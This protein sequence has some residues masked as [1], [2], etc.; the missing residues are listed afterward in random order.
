MEPLPEGPHPD[1]LAQSV[2]AAGQK[3]AE[4]AAVAALLAQVLAQVRARHAL[5]AA[6]LA[7]L[8]EADRAAIAAQWATALHPEWLAD[9]TLPETARAWGAALAHEGTDPAAGAA[10]DAAEARLRELHPYAMA[11]YDRL[12]SQGLAREE[13]MRQAVPSFLLDPRPRPAPR[14][15]HQGR[16]LTAS[17]SG[18]GASHPARPGPD[19][20]AATTAR[21]LGII[22]G[23]ND[24]AITDGRGPLDPAVVEMALAG[25][26]NAPPALIKRIVEGLRDGS[27]TVPAAA[28]RPP[29]PTVAAAGPGTAD[30]PRPAG[31]GVAA[32]ALRQAAGARQARRSR[33]AAAGSRTATRRKLH[34]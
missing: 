27:L 12:R 16:Y 29:R 4:L 9:A 3:L 21:L 25:R 15:A 34:P 26:T 7:A 6:E 11:I 19:P 28:A 2:T 10:L 18:P 33:A 14:D 24:A 17:G 20:D 1:P 31:D 5:A 23:L 32:V 30:W 8:E 13:A 22:A